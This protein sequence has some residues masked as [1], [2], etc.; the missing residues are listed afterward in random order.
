MVL[1][2]SGIGLQGNR[3]NESCGHEA[4]KEIVIPGRYLPLE[5]E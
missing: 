5:A 2:T 3:V 1:T 4:C